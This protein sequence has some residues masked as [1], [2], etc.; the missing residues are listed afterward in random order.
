M[1]KKK[2]LLK[3]ILQGLLLIA[4]ATPG[5]AENR[6][7]AYTLS[8]FVGGYAFD[9]DQD[10]EANPTHGLRAGYNFTRHWAAEAVFGYVLTE[11][12]ATNMETDSY[13]YGLDA[14]YHFRPEK[15]LVPFI[16]AGVG[17]NT[18]HT[19]EGID[20]SSDWLFNYGLGLKYFITDSVALRGDVRHVLV[21]EDDTLHFEDDTLNN[22]EYSAGVT[23]L[24][25]GKKKA[26][27]AISDT[28]APKVTFTSP[29]NGATD[30]PIYRKVNVAFSEEM[31]PLTISTATFKLTGPAGA[32]ATG[33]V[34]YDGTTTTASFTSKTSLSTGTLYTGTI[35]TGAKDLA[36][37]PLASNYEW[38]FTTEAGADT[39]A[40]TVSFV[41]P[42]NAATAAPLNQKVN[43]AFSEAMDPATITAATFSLKQGTT[44]VS[45]KVT[46]VASTATFTPASDFEKGKAYTATIAT[47][48]KD[49]AGNALAANYVWN[50]TALAAPKVMPEVL[51]SLEDSHFDYNSAEIANNGKTILNLNIKALKENPKMKIRIAGY[52]SAAGTEEYNQKLSERRATAVKE[53]IVKVGGIDKDRL[54]TIG[55]GET[56]PTEYEVVPS[57]I[58]SDEAKANM[59]VLFE[60]I[61]K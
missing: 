6:K 4:L 36:G 10:L 23:F 43:A 45:G 48:A 56:S 52:A 17:G 49:L 55:Y 41:A 7:G 11:T 31:D 13:S 30:V 40:P 2:I 20:D 47:G 28:D 53:Y 38:I 44:P 26:V 22:L 51:I 33:K 16:A 61:V 57:D 18:L 37:N 34:D 12:E 58:Y 19:P 14:L 25:G 3:S 59:K 8:P 32:P 60:V 5:F 29:T 24:F 42:V 39:T 9:S 35:T 46:S 15:N 1:K 21:F 50:F 54:T 27:A